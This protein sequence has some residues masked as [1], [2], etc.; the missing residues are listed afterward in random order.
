MVSGWAEHPGGRHHGAHGG[1]VS[2]SLGFG[3]QE[4]RD[5]SQNINPLGTPPAALEAARRALYEESGSYPDL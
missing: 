3:S 1:L 2:R 4:L 5:Y